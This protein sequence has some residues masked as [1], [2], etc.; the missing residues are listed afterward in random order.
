MDCGLVIDRIIGIGANGRQR[1]VSSF[2]PRPSCIPASKSKVWGKLKTELFTCGNEISDESKEKETERVKRTLI[3]PLL[4]V[5]YLDNDMVANS[6]TEMFQNIYG[7]R[8]SSRRFKKSEWKENLALAYSIS[9]TLNKLGISRPL[10][11]I[12]LVCGVPKSEGSKMMNMEKWLNM[13]EKEKTQLRKNN[14][15]WTN[16]APQHYIDSL[17]AHLNI[18]FK[19]ASEATLLAEENEYQLYGSHPNTLAAACLQ[20]ILHKHNMFTEGKLAPTEISK[21][22]G[23]DQRVVN[24][25]VMKVVNLCES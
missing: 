10:D 4:S 23:C 12:L 2:H 19:I 8:T 3:I 11:D 20:Y 17:C 5:F 13:D 15:E 16:P 18:P 25:T 21:A 22:L 6:V 9:N 1:F 7:A 24:E 14:Y